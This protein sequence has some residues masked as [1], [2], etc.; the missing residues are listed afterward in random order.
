MKTKNRGFTLI[1]LLVVIAI[2]G[3]L[4][5]IIFP[6]FSAAKDKGRQTVCLSNLKQLGAAFRMYADEWNG[7]FPVS[8]V[9]EGGEGN[10]AGNWC[11]SYQVG[12]KCD[13]S[14]GQ[15][16]PYV[17]NL[18][19]YLCPSSKGARP[20]R[21]TDPEAFPF[22]LSY[23]MNDGLSFVNCDFMAA[24]PEKVGLLIHEDIGTI[25]DG[26][27]NWSAWANGPGGYN[28][29]SSV[30][31]GGT[32]VIYCDLHGKWKSKDALMDELKAGIWNPYQAEGV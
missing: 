16:F 11:G 3:I 14:L 1:E 2:I 21:I 31:T 17:K 19:M 18:Q 27:F 15:I 30:H 20:P 28:A 4:A 29:P 24:L 9:I 23:S 32:C 12:S 22:N 8:R 10:P 6:V 25:D 7:C 13:P 5:A 26:D